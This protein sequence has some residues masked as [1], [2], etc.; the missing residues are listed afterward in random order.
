[1]ATLPQKP[2]PPNQERPRVHRLDAYKIRD[3]LENRHAAELEAARARLP[4][5]LRHGFQHLSEYEAVMRKENKAAARQISEA[6]NRERERIERDMRAWER[7]LSERRRF[8]ERH[9]RFPQE[10]E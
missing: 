7:H 1:M 2:P 8:F 9:G 5:F 4:F 10:G 3:E 6:R